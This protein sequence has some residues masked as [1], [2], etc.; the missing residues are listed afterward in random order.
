MKLFLPIRKI[1]YSKSCWKTNKRGFTLIELLVTMAVMVALAVFAIP[2][3]KG[4]VDNF[5]GNRAVHEL[6]SELHV[7]RSLAVRHG[8]N[9]TVTFDDPAAGQYTITW[10][11]PAQ[12]RVAD[13]A[14]FRGGIQFENNPPLPPLPPVA[15]IVFTPTGLAE[16]NPPGW[17]NIYITDRDNTEDLCIEVTLA[18]AI[19]ELKHIPNTNQWIY[20]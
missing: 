20:K 18:G 16:I 2:S 14:A 7:A 6:I 11:S 8:I 13:L 10:G 17:G 3:I 4:L 19:S 15:S 12:S 5:S 1:Q 9:A